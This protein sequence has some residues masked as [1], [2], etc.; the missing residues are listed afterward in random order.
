MA[1]EAETKRAQE[2][3]Q[4]KQQEL[5][6]IEQQRQHEVCCSLSLASMWIFHTQIAGAWCP[7]LPYWHEIIPHKY[8][9]SAPAGCDLI[10]WGLRDNGG[11]YRNTP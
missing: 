2:A 5:Q 6:Q 8:I 9:I 3:I 11:L 7:G 1:A 4:A 10:H